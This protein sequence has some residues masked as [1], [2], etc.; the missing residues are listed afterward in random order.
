MISALKSKQGPVLA[1]NSSAT[2]LPNES[3]AQN[4][5][6]VP[7]IRPKPR[8]NARRGFILLVMFRWQTEIHCVACEKPLFWRRRSVSLGATS[9]VGKI[10]NS[11]RNLC[12]ARREM[13]FRTAISIALFVAVGACATYQQYVAHGYLTPGP[14]SNPEIIGVYDTMLECEDAAQGWAGRQ[15]VGN[16]IFTEC[17]P[18]D[19]N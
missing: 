2:G 1:G 6:F 18:A 16:P 10:M 13:C 5:E 12:R 3:S 19:R 8:R 7:R 17:L 4:A 14:T 9:C 15:V 11:F